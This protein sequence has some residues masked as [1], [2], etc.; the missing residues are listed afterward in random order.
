MGSTAESY[1]KEFTRHSTDMMLNLNEMRKREILTDVKVLVEGQEFRAHKAVLVACSGFFYSIF[2]DQ[3]KRH[4][5]LLTLPRGVTAGGFH[6]LLEFMYTSCLPLEL[7][8]VAEVLTAAS[9]LQMEHVV[10]TCRSFA[11]FRAPLSRTF[12]KSPEAPP[13]GHPL[14]FLPPASLFPGRPLAPPLGGCGLLPDS[15]F[16]FTAGCQ[17][18]GG[19]RRSAWLSAYQGPGA[20]LGA[21]AAARGTDAGKP[22]ASGGESGKP[23]PPVPDS[24]QRSDCR[25]NSPTESKSAGLERSPPPADPAP[26]PGPPPD[27]KA[28]NWKKY[29]FIVL[30]SLNQAGESRPQPRP[31][32]R[33][34][35]SP[36]SPELEAEEEATQSE[37]ASRSSSDS[38]ESQNYSVCSVCELHFQHTSELCHHILD[39]HPGEEIPEY[40]S[41]FSDSGSEN[42]LFSC[43]ACQLKL[44]DEE[45]LQQHFLQVHSDDKPYKCDMCRAAFRYK[46]NLASHKTIHT[47]EK[48]YRCNVCGAQFNRPAN[49]KTHTRIH[50]GE[51]PYKCETCG[52]RFVQVAHLRAHVLIHTGEKPY[53]CETCGTRF[54]HLQTLKSHIRIHTG[55]K[56]YHCEKCDLHFR[57]KSQLR[58]HLR[59]KHGAVTNTKVRYKVVPELCRAPLQSC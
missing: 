45:S 12:L 51:K 48:P 25:P 8:S 58:L 52:A 22:A 24:P 42:G 34:R 46:G 5:N 55:E 57:H 9:Y 7:A 36:S 21:R 17:A 49:L 3:T 33:G 59:Q 56:P 15:A 2:S 28:C 16:R 35:R 32:A 19:G 26:T 53:P 27:P 54:R 47:G 20:G 1:V 14:P 29:K 50:S 13:A 43:R 37:E 6:L 10:E 38:R 39:S 40:H 41:E 18:D 44:S 4:V 30:N 23:S 11:H 31:E